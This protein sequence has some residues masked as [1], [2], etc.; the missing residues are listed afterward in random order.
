MSFVGDDENKQEVEILDEVSNMDINEQAIVEDQG[1]CNDAA[2]VKTVALYENERFQVTAFGWSKNGLLPTDRRHISTRNGKDG[3]ATF[4]AAEAAMITHGWTWSQNSWNIDYDNSDGEGWVYAASFGSI[5]TNG[6]AVKGMTHFVRRRRRTRQQCF[7]GSSIIKGTCD[8]CDSQEVL[9]ISD[10]MLEALTQTSLYENPGEYSEVSTNI[11]KNS[12]HELL[13]IA[14]RAESFHDLAGVYQ[15]LDKFFV[16]IINK[17]STWSKL[18]SIVGAD[19]L[20]ENLPHRAVEVSR[21]SFPLEERQEIARMLIRKYDTTFQYHCD[22]ND[23]GSAC[24]FAITH[25]PNVGCAELLSAKFVGS[26]LDSCMFT[27][28]PCERNCGETVVRK[29]MD[30]HLKLQCVLRSAE[31]PYECIGCTPDGL[32]VAAMKHHMEDPAW[33]NTHLK[34]SLDRLNEQQ[35]VIISLYK[36]V[37]QLEKTVQAQSRTITALQGGAAATI[38]A[39]KSSEQAAEDQSHREVVKLERR[40]EKQTGSMSKKMDELNR[41]IRSLERENLEQKAKLDAALYTEN[42]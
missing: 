26:H 35:G 31:C 7:V 34:L 32:T 37:N 16:T 20:P 9:K 11:L 38:V 10:C 30:C 33:I 19:Y 14:S 25:C 5:E 3:W 17:K 28:L 18:S 41:T 6:S 15:C 1:C 36:K 24:V 42:K 8:H 4:E 27:P 12:L 23:C 39:I 13:G 22:K 21:T 29:E 2:L 40:I